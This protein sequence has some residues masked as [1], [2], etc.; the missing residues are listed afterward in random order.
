VPP[1]PPGIN[2]GAFTVPLHFSV[3]R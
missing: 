3:S 2:G 1:A